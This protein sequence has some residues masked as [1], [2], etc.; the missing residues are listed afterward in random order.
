MKGMKMKTTFQNLWDATK[1]IG[2]F[3][4]LNACIRKER[5]QY[6]DFSF[7]FKKLEEKEKSKLK[8]Y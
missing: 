4:G 5:S 8:P 1:Y 3:I 7:Y 6:S 2:K